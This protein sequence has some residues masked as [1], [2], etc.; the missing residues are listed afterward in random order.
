MDYK[1]HLFMTVVPKIATSGD[2]NMGLLLMILSGIFPTVVFASIVLAL[3]QDKME[4][5]GLNFLLSAFE[6][7]PITHP[8]CVYHYLW[9]IPLQKLHDL[10]FNPYLPTIE[11][12]ALHQC[13]LP[14]S[15]WI[16]L[17]HMGYD[18]STDGRVYVEPFESRNAPPRTT[19]ACN[20]LSQAVGVNGFQSIIDHY[21]HLKN[22]MALFCFIREG[23]HYMWDVD[24]YE[25]TLSLLPTVLHRSFIGH[26]H[27]QE[28]ARCLHNMLEVSSSHFIL[29]EIVETM[30]LILLQQHLLTEFKMLPPH[31]SFPG[32]EEYLRAQEHFLSSSFKQD[33]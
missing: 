2:I 28:L 9:S 14:L 16:E 15:R 33:V 26:R 25:D 24:E 31:H 7:N 8:W 32:G 3:F 29:K 13:S 23:F 19:F 21:S 22:S 12:K 30:D 1:F 11:G 17:F 20:M 5:R 27:L 10:G 6:I 4:M 18:L